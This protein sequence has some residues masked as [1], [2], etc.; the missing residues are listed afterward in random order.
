MNIIK[1]LFFA[2]VYLCFLTSVSSYAMKRTHS[3]ELEER[4]TK[5]LCTAQDVNW[6]NYVELLTKFFEIKNLGIKERIEYLCSSKTF[7]QTQTNTN[8]TIYQLWVTWPSDEHFLLSIFTTQEGYKILVSTADINEYD[9]SKEGALILVYNI[10]FIPEIII[11]TQNNL[12]A[13]PHKDFLIK[14]LINEWLYDIEPTFVVTKENSLEPSDFENLL[15]QLSTKSLGEK[16]LTLNNCALGVPNEYPLM[17]ELKENVGATFRISLE[18]YESN[19]LSEKNFLTNESNIALGSLLYYR[20]ALH[21]WDYETDT[22]Q[23]KPSVVIHIPLD[24]GYGK[25]TLPSELFWIQKEKNFS[26]KEMLDFVTKIFQ[27]LQPKIIYLNDASAKDPINI[28]V[29][30]PIMCGK[31]FYEHYGQFKVVDGDK[32]IS[33]K[34]YPIDQTENRHKQSIEYVKSYPLRNLFDNL[35]IIKSNELLRIYNK[36]NSKENITTLGEYLKNLYDSKMNEDLAIAYNIVSNYSN[37]SLIKDRKFRSHM[38]VLDCTWLFKCEA[39]AK[40]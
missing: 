21:F 4:Q 26:G 17:V 36:I 9:I 14:E 12:T 7:S 27:L 38:A 29:L 40:Y 24:A 34:N 13:M 37:D 3:T 31:T 35:N 5:K 32:L 25:P 23:E 33:H 11:T 20:I 22:E 39:Y 18:K 8:E 6:L 16:I 1:Q 15:E 19:C 28:R 2:L 30:R 10:S